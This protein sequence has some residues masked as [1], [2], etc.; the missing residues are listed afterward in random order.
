MRCPSHAPCR[1][2]YSPSTSLGRT[3]VGGHPRVRAQEDRWLLE[4]RGRHMQQAKVRR[5]M[6]YAPGLPRRD[7]ERVGGTELVGATVVEHCSSIENEA[8]RQL[9]AMTAEGEGFAVAGTQST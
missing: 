6:S 7:H 9:A 8:E 1:K 4:C 3:G 2:K 5:R